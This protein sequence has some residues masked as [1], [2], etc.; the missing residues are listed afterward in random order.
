MDAEAILVVPR[1]ALF[2]TRTLQGFSADPVLV[3]HFTAVIVREGR[4][5]PCRPA[6]EDESLKQ[7]VPY[8]VVLHR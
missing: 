6:E 2:A 4:F 7:I 3:A 1:R 5:V 8:G